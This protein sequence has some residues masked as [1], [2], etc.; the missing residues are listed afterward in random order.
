MQT[1]EPTEP[2]VL[3][4]LVILLVMEVRVPYIIMI[5]NYLSIEKN[6]S[7]CAM[8]SGHKHFYSLKILYEMH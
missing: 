5:V 6:K 1:G 2:D 3:V 4:W 8:S 7:D